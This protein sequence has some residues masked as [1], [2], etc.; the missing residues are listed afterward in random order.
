[1]ECPYLD[2]CVCVWRESDKCSFSV[3]TFQVLNKWIT[4]S[5]CSAEPQMIRKMN[6]VTKLNVAI[7]SDWIRTFLLLLFCFKPVLFLFCFPLYVR[8]SRNPLSIEYICW[9][10]AVYAPLGLLDCCQG[11]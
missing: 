5:L 7:V 8:A 10:K 1:M 4:P 6:E 2:V 3:T 9:R 11:P